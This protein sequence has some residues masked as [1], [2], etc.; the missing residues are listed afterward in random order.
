MTSLSAHRAPA[1]H[2]PPALP[3]STLLV[4]G[5]LLLGG[6][7]VGSMLVGGGAPAAPLPGLAD[8]GLVT[9]WGAPVVDL[10]VAG[11]PGDP[12]DEPPDL[13][14]RPA[15]SPRAVPAPSAGRAS[16]GPP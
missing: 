5:G 4:G 16:V 1:P 2:R 3:P 10:L 6:V 9:G 15:G 12:A 7:L 14:G 8:P 11:R 13:V